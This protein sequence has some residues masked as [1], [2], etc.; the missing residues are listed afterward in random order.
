MQ[1]TETLSQG[2][3]RS[4][5]VVLPM[6]DLQTRLDT[7]LNDM[8]DKVRINGFRP[9]KVPVAHLRRVYGRSVM[10]EV[11]QGALDEA[12]KKI[13]SDNNLR[14]ALAPKIDFPGGDK[15]VEQALEARGD[16][17]F[18][19]NLEILPKIDVG[20]FDDVALERPVAAVTDD[21]VD[22]VI[23]RMA[24]QNRVF[25]PKTGGAPVAGKGDKVAVDYVGTI[26]GEAFEGGTGENVDLIL[27]SDTF[28][29]GF[30]SQ[31][32]G[33]KQGETRTID[34]TFP[35]NYAA[36]KLAG[37]AAQ[38]VVT[39]KV[40]SVPDELVVDDAFAKNF[41]FDELAKLKEAIRGNL[42]EQYARMSRDK[43]KRALLD[44]LDKRY[45][46][47][48]PEGLV[49]QEFESIWKQVQGERQESGKS[50]EDEGT[51][52]ETQRADYR[53]IAERRVRL[54]LLLAEVGDKAEVKVSDEEVT[55]AL[56]E[57]A[58]SYPGQ[59]KMIWDHYRKNPEAL[60][61]IR[62]PLY[63]EKVV[64]HI[65]GLAKVTDKPV[66][67]DDLYKM[68]EADEAGAAG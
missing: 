20:A 57:R 65:I 37:Q 59:E 14:L 39:A 1:V 44:A 46:F 53:R 32:E 34:V 36:P 28:I 40:V 5:A 18:T 56:I 31:I 42:T 58:R 2:L 48:L 4:F 41:G 15:D 47:D 62:A 25:T 30:E 45:S 23:T 52:E 29:P 21:E 49:E 11:V 9:G 43:V 13:V 22:T 6:S 16:L 3:K 19:V 17:A 8:K 64:D 7:Q 27:G 24:N 50:F 61:E 33:I 60:A 26:A 38:F 12:N 51:T 67:K 10:G 63:E 68:A 55:K 66:A 35:E 54:G